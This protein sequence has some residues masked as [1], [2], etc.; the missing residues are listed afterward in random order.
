MLGPLSV[1][2]GQLSVAN[3]R[4]SQWTTNNE[5]P[6]TDNGQQTTDKLMHL[7]DLIA[8]MEEIAPTRYAEE[9]DNVGLLAGDPAQPIRR[10]LLTIDYTAAVADEAAAL[11]AQAVIA[12]HPPLFRAIKH[13]RAG[14]LVFD[15]IRRGIAL[16]S[17]HTAWD[18]AS[19]GA[20]DLL[21]DSL[22][23]TT[24]RPLRAAEAESS[25][26]KLVVFVPEDHVETVS[27]ALFNAGAGQI[28][29]Y[30]HCSFRASGTG[31]FKP[32]AGANPTIGRI[33]Q[34]ERVAEARLEML[35]PVADVGRIIHTLRMV[36]P[37][38]EPAFDLFKPAMP[39]GSDGIGRIGELTPAVDRADLIDRVKRSL[40][41]SQLLIAG[42]TTGSASSA[43]CCAGAGSGLLCS[44]I[45]Q[46]ADV[47][48][49]GELRHHDALAAT[50]VGMTVLC[51]L[52]SNSERPSLNR[53]K[54]EIEKRI[55]PLQLSISQADRDPFT[56]G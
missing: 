34:L 18:V 2:S 51:T 10:A 40:G 14:N 30:T 9:W 12:Y 26:Y 5:A 48:L 45:A 31:T 11:D 6:T 54:E 38:E 56:I 47:Y 41:L 3:T 1:V 7:K 36:H 27:D 19:G 25:H 49:T 44:A 22:G 50:A 28:G 46:K 20:N 37:Y 23:L 39:P 16:Y 55:P 21:A 8:V 43:A 17:P 42:P 35:I 33:D 29:H 52:H 13:L 4:R 32:H 15:A 24:R 53:L